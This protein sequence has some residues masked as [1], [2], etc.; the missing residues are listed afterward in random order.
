MATGRQIVRRSSTLLSK[1]SFS[2]STQNFRY[3]STVA[4]SSAADK[5]S[6]HN[7]HKRNHVYLS[8]NDFIGSWE[9]HKNPKQAESNLAQLRR[10]YARQVKELRKQYIC[11][12]ELQRQ[13]KLRKD[14]ARREEI[15][16]EREERKKSKA[17]A[18]EARA[19]ERKAFEEDFRQT[20]LKEKTEKLE[21]WRTREKERKEKKIE[22]KQLLHRQSSMW[23]DERSGFAR[24][25][26]AALIVLSSVRAILPWPVFSLLT[27]LFLPSFVL[28]G[29]NNHLHCEGCFCSCN[30][31]F[32]LFLNP[33]KFTHYLPWDLCSVMARL[34]LDS[35]STSKFGN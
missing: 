11:E 16:R 33:E 20:L 1:T 12:M 30:H 13:E 32:L 7:D 17:A 27:G 10:D 15:R 6:H 22:K 23:I 14:E 4:P 8:P 21:Y 2:L 34:I 25:D 31:W 35:Y 9:P 3:S 5:P 28:K 19:A 29:E 24:E 26:D 18:A